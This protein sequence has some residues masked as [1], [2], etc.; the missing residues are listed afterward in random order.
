MLECTCQ[1]HQVN[2]LLQL[3][4]FQLIT[5]GVCK[6]LVF[7]S[8]GSCH[9]LCHL[10]VDPLVLSCLSVLIKNVSFHHQAQPLELCI[11]HCQFLTT[12]IL[13]A[14]DYGCIINEKS[15]FEPIR[16]IE[17]YGALRETKEFEINLSVRLY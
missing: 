5:L 11:L 2:N 4:Q 14:M 13:G 3:S 10:L 6:C 1:T 12:S 8:K 16:H 9:L 17:L 15:I 7:S